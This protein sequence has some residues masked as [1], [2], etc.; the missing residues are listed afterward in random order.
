MHRH[1]VD[2]LQVTLK[3]LAITAVGVCKHHHLAL[4]VAAHGDKSVFEGQGAEIHRAELVDAV[5]RQIAPRLGVDQ[6][7]LD[8]KIAFGVGVEH[9]GAHAHLIQARHRRTAHFIDFL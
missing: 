2:L 5:F 8:Q 1:V 7:T 6:L 4:S 9:I 3:A